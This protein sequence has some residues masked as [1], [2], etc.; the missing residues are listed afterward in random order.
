MKHHTGQLVAT[1]Q[2]VRARI[3]PWIAVAIVS[4]ALTQQANSQECGTWTLRSESGPDPRFAHAMAFDSNRGVTV[5]YGGADRPGHHFD[6]TWEWDGSTW[7]QRAVQ[8][9][10]PLEQHAMA[11]DAAR[12]ETVLFGGSIG[13]GQDQDRTWVWNGTTWTERVCQTH[14]AARVNPRMVYDEVAQVVVLFGGNAQFPG[15]YFG[16]TWTWNGQCWTQVSDTGPSGRQS[17][18][19]TYDGIRQ[20]VLLHGG[21]AVGRRLS[22]SL[23]WEWDG[24]TWTSSGQCATPRTAHAMTF[25]PCA[26]ALT[27]FGGWEGQVYLGDTWINCTECISSGPAARTAVAV[28]DSSRRVT[29]LFGGYANQGVVF[30]ETWEFH[31]S[32]DSDADGL[33]DCE[34]LLLGTDPHDADTDD[35]GLNDGAEVNLYGTD[36]LEADTDGDGLSDGNEIAIQ[37]FGCP[38]PLAFDTDDDGLSD[39]FEIGLGLDACGNSDHDSDGL[40]D[41]Q[42]VLDYGTDPRNPDTDGDGLND[43]TEVDMAAGT[44]C[45]N[46]LNPDSDGDTLSDGAEVNLGTDPCNTDTDGD[47]VADNTDDRPTEPG[48]SSGFIEEALRN[49]CAYIDAAPLENFDAPNDNARGGR[50]NAMCNKLNATA[51]AVAADDRQNAYVRLQSLLQKLDGNEQP[52]DWMVPGEAKNFVHDEIT[53]LAFLISL[54]I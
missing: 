35:D 51:R 22:D 5:L 29:V 30:G 19:M 21:E 39:G 12:G 38:D 49:V 45:P 28:F 4:A 14:P 8:G 25:D 43:G 40:M 16:D 48:V 54:G 44:G 10:G 33:T 46:P 18:A 32:S 9:P 23:I 26:N 31:A 2:S 24:H 41:V 17:Q 52:P 15:I 53:L 1:N 13:N 11:F 3:R 27:I 6:D 7:I 34:E 47:G 37:E 20:R 50:R 36:P 42:E